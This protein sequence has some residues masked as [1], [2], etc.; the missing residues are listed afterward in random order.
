[1]S[2]R[3]SAATALLLLAGCATLSQP[4]ARQLGLATLLTAQGT[5][6]GWGVIVA[7]GPTAAVRVSLGGLPA[8]QH[9]LH[10][11]A[12]GRC[13]APDFASAGP[14]LNPA[15]REHGRSNPA[16]SHLGDLPNVEVG[17]DGR[18]ELTV[19][20]PGNRGELLDALFDRD[21]TAVVVHAER[22]DDRTDPAG[23]S[24][25]RI[26]CGVLRRS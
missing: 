21:G 20:L 17:V 8:G 4:P 3:W 19:V 14:H 26:A 6:A 24:G 18:G 5:P 1:M 13:D 23:N 12:A 11:H 9:G 22:D 16:G 15:S 2:P 7:T 10:L 25:A